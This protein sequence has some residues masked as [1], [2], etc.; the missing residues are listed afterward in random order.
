MFRG[1]Q[2]V[3][4]RILHSSLYRHRHENVHTVHGYPQLT[5]FAKK[6]VNK[7]RLKSH[8]K[9]LRYF[10]CLSGMA[11]MFHLPQGVGKWFDE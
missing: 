7:L 11:K 2:C 6:N 8:K 3:M 10:D 1:L 4:T 5:H 9:G